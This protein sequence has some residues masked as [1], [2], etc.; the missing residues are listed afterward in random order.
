MENRVSFN[1][2]LASLMWFHDEKEAKAMYGG[3]VADFTVKRVTANGVELSH[4][5][6]TLSLQIAQQLTRADGGDWTVSTVPAPAEVRESL[7]Q[8]AK[9][10]RG[11]G[12]QRLAHRTSPRGG[13]GPYFCSSNSASTTS[14]FFWPPPL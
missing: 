11:A 2:E 10:E 1:A 8:Q 9:K 12:I 6:K 5:Q 7:G 3:V 4:G 14:S 13:N